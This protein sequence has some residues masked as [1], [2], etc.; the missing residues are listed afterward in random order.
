MS[1]GSGA[2][3][4]RGLGHATWARGSHRGGGGHARV[5]PLA[6]LVVGPLSPDDGSLVHHP[7]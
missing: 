1:R 6:R 5:D 4:V 7:R 2:R 3:L